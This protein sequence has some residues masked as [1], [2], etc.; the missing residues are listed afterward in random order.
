MVTILK[1]IYRAKKRKE[2]RQ[3]KEKEKEKKYSR[4]TRMEFFFS[5]VQ[6]T[7]KDSNDFEHH[8]GLLSFKMRWRMLKAFDLE[9]T[10]DNVHIEMN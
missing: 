2:R 7:L 9:T 3:R 8:F 6:F 1:C 4:S 10:L 5:R